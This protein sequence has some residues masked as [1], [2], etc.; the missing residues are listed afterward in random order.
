MIL[1]R[2]TDEVILGE[3]RRIDVWRAG[4]GAKTQMAFTLRRAKKPRWWRGERQRR[5]KLFRRFCLKDERRGRLSHHSH[6]VSRSC[7][8][9]RMDVG[10]TWRSLNWS[11]LDRRAKTRDGSTT[12]IFGSKKSSLTA[13]DRNTV[14]SCSNVS[15]KRS[16]KRFGA[17]GNKKTGPNC[18]YLCQSW[19]ANQRS[20]NSNRGNDRE[21]R[22][23]M[24]GARSVWKSTSANRSS[25][26]YRKGNWKT[27]ESLSRFSLRLS[28]KIAIGSM[29]E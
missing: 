5:R 4:D 3:S 13:G 10:K 16:S 18:C 22:M 26:R 12:G 2:L 27:Q 1:V 17:E 11:R 28:Y 29:K 6:V 25:G 8:M 7:S 15:K 21:T 19:S 24:S 20:T 14:N 23:G 9:R